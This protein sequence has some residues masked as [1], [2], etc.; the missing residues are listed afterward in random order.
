MSP[1]TEAAIT[2]LHRGWSMIPSRG[3]SK[4]PCLN[5]WKPYQ[6]AP[7]SESQLQDWDRVL[8]PDRWGLVTGAVSGVIGVDFDGE[9]GARWLKE[10]GLDPHVRS[11]GG[12]YHVYFTHPG[13]RVPTMNAKSGKNTWPWPGVDVRG[14]GGYIVLLGSNAGGDYRI[15]RD[16]EPYPF[17]QLPDQLG[18]F[19]RAKSKLE[20][21]IAP[22]TVSPAPLPVNPSVNIGDRLVGDALGRPL[23][24]GRNNAGFWLAIQLRDNKIPESEARRYLLNFQSRVPSVNPRGE[25]QLYT[26][27]EAEASLRSA[28]SEPAREPSYQPRRQQVNGHAVSAPVLAAPDPEPPLE[29]SLQKAR[30]LLEEVIAAKDSAK[31]YAVL[32]VPAPYITALAAAGDIIQAEARE[33]LR[34]VYKRDFVPSR[35]N[36]ELKTEVAKLRTS[37]PTQDGWQSELILK[38][39]KDGFGPPAPCVTNALLY[40]ENHPDWRGKL[41]WNEF[42]GEPLVTADL[43]SP[44]DLKAGEPVKDHHDTLVQSWLEKTTGDYKWSIDTVRRSVDCWAKAHSFHPVKD[45]LNSLAA[46]DGVER[47]PGWLP[48]YCGAGPAESDDS[49]EAARLQAFIA[50][51]GERWWISA[52][53]R[54]FQPG[55]KV[56]HVLVLEGLKGIGKSTIAEIVFGEYYA[57]ILGDVTTKDNQALLHAGVWGILMDE[58][59]VLGKSEMRS[60]KSWVTRDFEK[61]RPTWGHRHEKKLRQCV[62][63][64]TVNGDDWALEEDRRWWPITCRGQF[65]LDGLR[66]DRDKLMAE[67]LHKYRAGQRWYF[68]HE[69]DADLIVTAKIEQAARVPED[70]WD[71]MVRGALQKA[72]S[73]KTPEH[74]GNRYGYFVSKEEIIDHLP[75]LY[76]AQ[77]DAA[78]NRV[79]RVMKKVSGWSRAQVPIDGDRPW[80]YF[81]RFGG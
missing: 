66:A 28:Y 13:W 61:F 73:S 42:S 71:G 48:R 1:L 26:Q 22:A 58:L 5:T 51:I 75:P 41:A 59:D 46:W 27:A 65:D 36:L 80:R 31:I 79:G 7:P 14:D 38:P 23:S 34:A 39:A 81:L 2:F 24:N 54:I 11:A 3:D 17:D 77:R 62:F 55:C 47:L 19:L 18:K 21:A 35:W 29:S 60:V 69:E 16:L 70:T 25:R 9:E 6:T 45:Y 20:E 53:A 72:L 76:Q 49:D 44:V 4:G 64:A 57:V 32:D 10:W 37:A 74:L 56:H 12:G 40:F 50:A 68:D 78:G 67:A 8:N 33:R 30:R 15:L 43:P 52:I 63:M